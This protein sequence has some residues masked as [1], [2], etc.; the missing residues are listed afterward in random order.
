MTSKLRATARRTRIDLPM[1]TRTGVHNFFSLIFFSSGFRR[2]ILYV[3]LFFFSFPFFSIFPHRSRAVADNNN[4]C[5]YRIASGPCGGGPGYRPTN[6]IYRVR[7]PPNRLLCVQQSRAAHK[8][9]DDADSHDLGN[10]C[11]GAGES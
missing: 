6:Q 5:A 1:P 8:T 9:D 7:S 3:L 11:T 10:L 2:N 4:N